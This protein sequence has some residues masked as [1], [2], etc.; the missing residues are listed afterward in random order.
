MRFIGWSRHSS[1]GLLFYDMSDDWKRYATALKDDFLFKKTDPKTNKR[2]WSCFKY[3][4]TIYE[5]PKKFRNDFAFNIDGKWLRF[6]TEYR[7]KGGKPKAIYLRHKKDVVK[8]L[9]YFCRFQRLIGV[10]IKEELVYHMTCFLGDIVK[11]FK[12]VFVPSKENVEI[13]NKVAERILKTECGDD[14]LER[15]KDDRNFCI[16]PVRLERIDDSMKSVLRNKGKRF[17]NYLRIRE[18]YDD[19]K[20]KAENAVLC[21]VSEVTIARFR[22]DRDKL[23]QIYNSCFKIEE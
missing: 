23:E 12:D 1:G 5:S 15:L 16:S 20:S 18:K 2:L 19:T 17:A 9:A 11:L 13:L 4:K 7:T 10:E 22:R 3:Q 6:P 8:E 21:G 14:T